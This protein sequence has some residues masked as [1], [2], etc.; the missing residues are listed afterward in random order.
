[1]KEALRNHAS[2]Q[3][4]TSGMVVTNWREYQTSKKILDELEKKD[5][6]AEHLDI[7]KFRPQ[8]QEDYMV[9][10]KE[11]FSGKSLPLVFVRDKLVA[12]GEEV[13][14]GLG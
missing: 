8:E 10:L 12:N 11:L 7:S 6:Y 9:C 4:Y 13:L 3:S 5:I 1:M 14:S 2:E